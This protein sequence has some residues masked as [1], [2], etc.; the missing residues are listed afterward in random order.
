MEW[1]TW[2]CLELKRHFKLFMQNLSQ[3]VTEHIFLLSLEAI[4]AGYLT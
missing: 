1:Q 3:N 4:L 2:Q